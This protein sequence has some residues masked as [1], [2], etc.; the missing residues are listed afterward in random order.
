MLKHV[1]KKAGEDTA[2]IRPLT[3]AEAEILRQ[4]VKNVGAR[5]AYADAL[6]DEMAILVEVG[7]DSAKELLDLSASFDVKPTFAMQ[8]LRKNADQFGAL[9]VQ[10]EQEALLNTID[11]GL[12]EGWTPARLADELQATFDEGYHAFN[13]AG[14]LERVMPSDQ[15]S[16]MVA[17]TELSRAQTMGNIAL[18]QAAQVEKVLYATSQGENVCDIC[19]P[20]DGEIF[21]MSDLDDDNTPPLHPRCVC[22]LIP[23]DSDVNP[24]AE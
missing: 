3:P 8:E 16:E 19:E 4:I 11:E 13:D 17:R 6:Y 7:W 24:E 21:S 20:L 2:G 23:A 22:A 9:I 14:Q 5:D 15:W 10:R 12:S 1:A 18:Y